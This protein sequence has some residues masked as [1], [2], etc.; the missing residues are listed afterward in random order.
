[1]EEIISEFESRSRDITMDG[2]IDTNYAQFAKK[3]RSDYILYFLGLSGSFIFR[4]V[5][6][7]S[8]QR[9]RNYVTER[10]IKK[11]GLGI[12]NYIEC[13]ARRELLLKG[14]MVK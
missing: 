8:G 11:R 10:T 4:A 9:L 2:F 14:I 5:N 6:K 3:M 13:E 1:M 7:I 12:R